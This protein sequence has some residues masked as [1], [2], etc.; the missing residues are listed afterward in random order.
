MSDFNKRY[1]EAKKILAKFKNFPDYED[2]EQ[3]VALKLCEFPAETVEKI[4]KV[5]YKRFLSNTM[6][7]K[8]R[9]AASI[10]NEDGERLDDDIYFVDLSTVEQFGET[11]N[12]TDEL[13]DNVRKLEKTLQYIDC[14]Y[15][16]YYP[17]F[18]SDLH[19]TKIKGRLLIKNKVYKKGK[20]SYYFTTIFQGLKR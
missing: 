1:Q 17:C 10:Y 19:K 6:E 4:C 16:N 5:V 14:I 3:T 18:L 20:A 2:I 12:I 13:K 11:N 9:I 15:T 7:D 8:R